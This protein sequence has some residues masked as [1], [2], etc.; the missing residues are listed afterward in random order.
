VVGSS[1]PKRLFSE[2]KMLECLESENKI[3]IDVNPLKS[4]GNQKVPSRFNNT[5]ITQHLPAVDMNRFQV[6]ILPKTEPYC[7]ASFLID[8]RFPPEY[9]FKE[10]DITFLDPIYHPSIGNSGHYSGCPK[11][12]CDETYK[13]TTML[14]ETIEHVFHN[15]DS[16][17]DD[18][19]I[20]NY[21]CFVE[22][23]NDYQTFYRK[24]LE[25]TLSYGRPRD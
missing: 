7:R 14:V 2:I 9:P 18:S 24:A 25:H 23:Q 4:F 6:R 5:T 13:P 11:C 1:Y 20:C 16:N 21:E 19:H 22:Y 15:I 8:I 12:N 3:I 17:P 10:P